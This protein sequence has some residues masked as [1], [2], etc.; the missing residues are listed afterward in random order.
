MLPCGDEIASSISIV[1]GITR[2]IAGGTILTDDRIVRLA[3]FLEAS[4]LDGQR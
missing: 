2:S 3:L 4:G 1:S